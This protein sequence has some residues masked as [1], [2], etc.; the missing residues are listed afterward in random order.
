MAIDVSDKTTLK[1]RRLARNRS[2]RMAL[3]TTVVARMSGVLLQ[4]V[5]LPIAAVQLGSAGF[6]I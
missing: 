3:L 5:S 6:S 4:V 1:S 2:I